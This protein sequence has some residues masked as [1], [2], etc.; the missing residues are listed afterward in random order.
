MNDINKML[1]D[2]IFTSNLIDSL[3]CGI[4]VVDEEG[5]VQALNNI[6]EKVV[7]VT[8]QVVLGMG[9]GNALGCV[10]A[11]EHPGGCGTDDCCNYCE[12]RMLAL[13]VLYGNKKQRGSLYLQL[14]ID[15][16]V[17]DVS[18]LLSAVPVTYLEKRFAILIIEDITRLK[19]FSPPDTP[20]GFRGILGRDEKIRELIE[21]IRQVARTDAPVLL[22]GESGT[23]K[24]LVASAIHKESPRSHKYFVPVNC[25]ALPEGLIETDLFGHVKGAFTGAFRDKKGRFELAH[26]G[27]IFLDEVSE[28]K[29]SM[30]VKLLRVLQDGYIERVGSERTMRV[31][32]RV[33]SATNKDLESEVAAGRFRQDLYYRIC[34]LPIFPPP[35]RGRKGDIALLANHFLAL[36]SEESYGKR[37]RHSPEALAILEAH[38]WPGNVRELQN[39]LQFA[40]VKSQGHTIEPAHLP[41]PLQLG[42]FDPSSARRRKPKLRA[43]DVAETLRKAGGNMQKAAEILGVSRST[44]YRF[45]AEQKASAIEER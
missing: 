2:N 19:S 43:I 7:G 6:V 5:H 22:Q 15:G 16:Q 42:G 13:K 10:R 33:I 35:L 18:L 32:V 27:T 40:L 17:R 37:V 29:P 21:T 38:A 34:V 20:N 31:N 28:L 12:F 8:E 3:S 9:G 44:L 1:R 45:F 39:T 26:E 4:I 30:Q 41:L 25:G 23:G 24:E 14:V 11:N 36:F